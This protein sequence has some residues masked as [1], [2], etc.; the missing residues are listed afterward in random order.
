[1]I[2]LNNGL[3]KQ[4]GQHHELDGPGD[5]NFKINLLNL[6]WGP[7]NQNWKFS[8]V[9]KPNPFW[10]HLV[11]SNYTFHICVLWESLNLESYLI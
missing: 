1:M 2:R 9:Q 5:Q 3:I 6:M 7:I 8:Q 11:V 4:K 10:L